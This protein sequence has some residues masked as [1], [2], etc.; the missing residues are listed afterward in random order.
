MKV[1][2]AKRKGCYAG[3]LLLVAA[4]SAEEAKDVF[5]NSEKYL[6]MWYIRNNQVFDEYYEKFEL[7]PNLTYNTQ[8]PCVIIEDGHTE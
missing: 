7:V 8:L 5:H 3:G 1:Y 4:N 2:A 6:H